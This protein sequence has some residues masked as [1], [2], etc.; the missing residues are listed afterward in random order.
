MLNSLFSYGFSGNHHRIPAYDNMS[1]YKYW[2]S[3]Q[4]ALHPKIRLEAKTTEPPSLTKHINN[5]YHYEEAA[6]LLS[7]LNAIKQAYEAGHELAL[8]LEDDALLSNRF[9][10]E[11]YTYLSQ[12]PISWKILQFAT[13]MPVILRQ[14]ISLK[15]PFISWQPYH[16]STRAYIINRSGM[17]T[18][19]DKVF[20][21][22]PIGKGVWR[23]TEAP[24]V[25]SDEAV[26]ALV[27]D[28]YTSTLRVDALDLS[29]VQSDADSSATIHLNI[30]SIVSDVTVKK[31]E[32]VKKHDINEHTRIFS[33]SLLVLMSVR[34]GNSDNIVEE[35][36]RIQ[37]DYHAVCKFHRRC[38]W[39][40]SVSVVSPEFSVEF[41]QMASAHLPSKVNIVVQVS[42][43]PFNKFVHVRNCMDDIS[44]YDLLLLKDNDQRISGFPWNTFIETKGNAII[45]G[46]LRQDKKEAFLHSALEEKR[47][48]FLFHQALEWF[49][50]TWSSNLI[51]DVLPVEVPFLE[52]FFTL[53]DA[54]FAHYFFQLALTP[55]F[56]QQ[57]SSWGPDYLWCGA[58][59][60][61]DRHRPGCYLVPL[62]SS[63]ED[64]RQ[65]MKDKRF[66]DKGEKSLQYVFRQ[67]IF[68]HWIKD[69]QKWSHFIGGKN[70]HQIEHGCRSLLGSSEADPFCLQTC[71]SRAFL[72]RRPY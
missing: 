37:Q 60:V 14:G 42:S 63:H 25:V 34:I 20:S 29:T 27:G 64:T 3:G 17:K 56:V 40:I 22:S 2:Q 10:D 69:S 13:T 44:N 21:T 19:M 8:I 67:P 9:Q 39:K 31:H 72:S 59:K 62:V 16:W 71:L 24:L 5:V 70:L 54:K 12:A 28:A 41:Q 6:C 18:L 46:P 7:H 33:D 15:D 1:A 30:S 50:Y 26:Y 47:Q 43:E 48:Y 66:S 65:M 11:W 32:T 53:F 57:E 36:R 52:M 68:Q 23:I 51:A 38:E 45:S 61:W 55:A 35:I 49:N 58:A 4:L